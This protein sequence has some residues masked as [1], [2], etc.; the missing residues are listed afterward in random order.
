MKKSEECPL[1][2]T[3]PFFNSLSLPGSAAILKD[4]N[5]RADFGKCERYKRRAAGKEVPDNLW[6]NGKLI[7]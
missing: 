1:L 5:C 4:I 6:P 7:P 2:P 3:C